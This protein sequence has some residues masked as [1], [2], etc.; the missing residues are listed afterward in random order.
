RLAPPSPC[1]TLFRSVLG[2]RL[3]DLLRLAR[4]GGVLAPDEPLQRGHLDD[5]LRG[6]VGLGQPGR[7]QQQVELAVLIHADNRAEPGGKPLQDRK[8]TRLNSSHVK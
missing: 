7:A 5:E 1:T 3:G 6:E 2:N 4:A 8:S